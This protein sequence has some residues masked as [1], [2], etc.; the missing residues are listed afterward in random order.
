M[1]FGQFGKN[2]GIIRRVDNNYDMVKIFRRSTNHCR[3][4][5]V[6]IFDALRKG[7]LPGERHLERIEGYNK[8]VDRRDAMRQ[9]SRLVFGICADRKKPTMDFWVQSFHPS[10][11]EFRKA[12]EIGNIA[13]REPGSFKHCTCA[14]GR[15]ELDSKARKT[16]GERSKPGFVGNGNQRPCW[17]AEI[18]RHVVFPAEAAAPNASPARHLAEAQRSLDP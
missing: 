14:A 6:D 7:S 18:R 3:A 4:T 13:D 8:E 10:V 12:R 16:A 5:D 2:H 15:N 17:A 11:Q 1:M 9:H